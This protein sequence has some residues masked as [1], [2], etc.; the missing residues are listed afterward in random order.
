MMS[1]TF[2]QYPKSFHVIYLPTIIQ[3]ESP[4]QKGKDWKLLM[5]RPRGR[6]PL[7]QRHPR[8]VGMKN[9]RI[10]LNRLIECEDV[11]K[12]GKFNLTTLLS[13]VLFYIHPY[14][15]KY[16]KERKKKRKEE[17]CSDGNRVEIYFFVMGWFK[18][19]SNVWKICYLFIIHLI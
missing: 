19:L 16:S 13:F 12:S 17:Y 18:T 7:R 1:C 2:V 4:H 8:V 3:V 10:I 15:Y 14:N 9:L 11:V 6:L 5:N